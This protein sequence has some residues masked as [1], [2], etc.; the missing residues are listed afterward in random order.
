M[1]ITV[2]INITNRFKGF[3]SEAQQHRLE[4]EVQWIPVFT[5]KQQQAA[6]GQCQ[7]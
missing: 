7:V 1:H 6:A 2:I 4:D 3:L 5:F